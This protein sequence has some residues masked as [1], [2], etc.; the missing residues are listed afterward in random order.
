LK[1]EKARSRIKAI[2]E[3]SDMFNTVMDF[4][5]YYTISYLEAG[6][7][8]ANGLLAKYTERDTCELRVPQRL[9]FH[10]RPATLVAK[11][12][13]YYG[14]KV[15]I[16]V[17]GHR[18]DASNVLN[19]TLAGGL[20]ARKGYKTVVFEGDKRVLKDLKLLSECNYG[21]DEAGSPTKPPSELSHL[22][23]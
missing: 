11:C 12:A 6:K 17:D 1:Y 22:W 10:L 14:T 9:G 3:A 21:E 5:L 16:I 2:L 4:A 13:K 23:A 8:L 20:I 15:F 7:E 19:I 18:Y